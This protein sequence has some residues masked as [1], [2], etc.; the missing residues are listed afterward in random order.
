MR[1]R[2]VTALSFCFA[3]FLAVDGAGQNATRSAEAADSAE[4]SDSLRET[5]TQDIEQCV[6]EHEVA[7]QMRLQEQWLPAR[8]AMMSC[9]EARCPLAIA[10]DCRAWLDELDRVLPTLLIVVEHEGFAAERATLQVEL[11]GKQLSLPDPPTLLEL[12]PGPH[13]LRLRLGSRPAVERSFVL[14]KGEKNHVEQVRFPPLSAAPSAPRPPVARRPIQPATY[15]LS[16]AAV[17]AFA[18]S[19]ASFIWAVREHRDAQVRCAPTCDHDTRRSID[20]KLTVADVTG[21]VGI[22]LG[23][24]AIYSYLRRP[25]VFGAVS[26]ASTPIT[27]PS[28][29]SAGR[30]FSL[31]WRGAF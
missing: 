26:A 30:D 17:T 20:T 1:H 23:A 29:A 3:T 13:Q 22:A 9:S 5:S 4:A 18:G 28:F 16:A 19:A 8:A 7:R 27:G 25:V 21:G 11:D 6:A 14:G 31:L 24:L 15:W 10:A 2:V 12:L